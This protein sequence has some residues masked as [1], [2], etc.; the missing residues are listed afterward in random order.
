MMNKY[1]GTIYIWSP[2]NSLSLCWEDWS[3]F[4]P[5]RSTGKQSKPL[6]YCNSVSLSSLRL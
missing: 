5:M 2:P 6:L 3:A 4:V 1:A